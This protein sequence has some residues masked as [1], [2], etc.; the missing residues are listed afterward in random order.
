[1]GARPIRNSPQKNL[2]FLVC[3][4]CFSSLLLSP[5]GER[6]LRTLLRSPFFSPIVRMLVIRDRYD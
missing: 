6:A 5:R 2:L 1:V 3:C 4:G